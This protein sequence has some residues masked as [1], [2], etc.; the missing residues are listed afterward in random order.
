MIRAPEGDAQKVTHRVN[1][2]FAE[3]SVMTGDNDDGAF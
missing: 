1:G 3:L 2:T